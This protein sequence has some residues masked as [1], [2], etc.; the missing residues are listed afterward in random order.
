M[1]VGDGLNDVAALQQ[2]NVSFAL[3]SGSSIS[4]SVSDFIIINNDLQSVVDAIKIINQA[5][6]TIKANLI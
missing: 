4:K 1:F 5:K 2:A 6:K 3:T